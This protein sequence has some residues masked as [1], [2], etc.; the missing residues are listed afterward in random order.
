MGAYGKKKKN[1]KCVN[2]QTHKFTH[3]NNEYLISSLASVCLCT[4]TD[5]TRGNRN[6]QYLYK[7]I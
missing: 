1:S 3:L 7:C 4:Y 6:V 5:F 2:T